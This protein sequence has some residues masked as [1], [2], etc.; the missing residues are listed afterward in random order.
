MKI[1]FR[2][3]GIVFA[4]FVVSVLY[5]GYGAGLL[6]ILFMQFSAT[7]NFIW[8]DIFRPVFYLP[9]IIVVVYIYLKRKDR[10]LF[11]DSLGFILA[12]LLAMLWTLELIILI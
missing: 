1:K 7:L 4:A 12:L 11:L 10:G 8:L 6:L 9:G 5:L 2:E 3:I